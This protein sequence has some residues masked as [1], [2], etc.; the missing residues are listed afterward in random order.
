MTDYDFKAPN[1]AEI[2]G[3]YETVLGTAETR[4]IGPKA[5][6]DHC[7]G[8]DMHWDTSTTA[9]IAGVPM[10]TDENGEDWLQHH[11]IP[12]DAKPLSD[13]LIH[14]CNEEIVYGQA[15]EAQ[16][17][18]DKTID[19]LERVYGWHRSPDHEHLAKVT[20]KM[21]VIYDGLSRT[22]QMMIQEELRRQR[23][24]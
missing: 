13:V 23:Y 19:V 2:K 17:N 7:G 12:V 8:T 5:E 11:L 22:V 10:L 20:D 6:Y 15:L 1:G 4:F 24:D 9:D 14:K 16:I 18:L 3:T 21:R